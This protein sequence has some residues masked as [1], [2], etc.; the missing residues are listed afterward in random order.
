MSDRPKSKPAMTNKEALG[1]IV[2]IL[3]SIACGLLAAL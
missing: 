3:G 1:W 2:F